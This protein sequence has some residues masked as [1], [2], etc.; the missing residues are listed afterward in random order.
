[1]ASLIR[2]LKH[3]LDRRRFERELAEEMETHRLLTEQ[4]LRDDGMSATEAAATSRRVMGNTTL[5]REDVRGVWVST[6]LESVLQDVRYA[7][8][9]LFGRPQFTLVAC[10]TLAAAIGLNSSLF[11]AYGAIAWQP[12]AVPEADR[13]YNIVTD[14]GGTFSAAAS[15]YLAS[16]STAFER[17]FTERRAGN[18]IIGDERYRASWVSGHYF[19]GLRVPMAAGRGLAADDDI[20]GAPP[21]AVLSYGLWRRRF[22]EDT[23]L[24]GR[25]ITLD[26][27]RLTVV[28][29]T[30]AGFAGT[31]FERVDMWLPLA[32][33]AI[34]RP[35][36]RWVRDEVSVASGPAPR[37]SGYLALAG[38]LA[39]GVTRAQGETEL[40]SLASQF[41]PSRP[42]GRPGLRLFGTAGGDNPGGVNT[43]AFLR[44]FGAVLAV[45][46]LACANVGS[47][48]LARAHARRRE[49][50]MRLSLGASRSRVVRQLLIES[51]VLALC[52][53][54]L[55][56][57]LTLHL[58]RLALEAAARQ[59]TALQLRPDLPV[60][61]FTL[62]ICA[63][64]C[65][66]FG[67]APALHATRGNVAEAL[68]G[69]VPLQRAHFPLRSVMLSIQ[70]GLSVIL[71]VAAGLLIRGVQ[72]AH[73][74]D[75]GFEVNGVTLMSFEA[76]VSA[77]DGGRTRAFAL[78]L[79][80]QLNTLSEQLPIG[81]THVAP[82]GSGNLKG[83]YRIAG[84]SED[85]FN[86]VYEVSPSYFSVLRLP[87]VAGRVFDAEER[88]AVL[89]NETLARDFGSPAAAVGRTISAAP[90]P[91]WNL[92][93]DH[94]IVGVV[95][96]AHPTPLESVQPTIYQPLSG[97]TIPQVLVRDSG[98]GV[99][100]ISAIAAG[101]EPRIRVRVGPLTENIVLRLQ[102]STAMARIATT[103]G[104]LALLLA[105]VGMFSVFSFWVQQRTKEIGLRMALGARQAQVMQLV[106]GSSGRAIIAGLVLG[107][108]GAVGASSVLRSSLYGLS[109]ID[110]VSYLGVVLLLVAASLTAT[111]LPARRASRINPLDALRC[112]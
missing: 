112:E 23:G 96:D 27:V 64:A 98:E 47:L 66:L 110:P 106:L 73:L 107:L 2:R 36:D 21:V 99:E 108:A 65:L 104:V 72:H 102:R 68:K 61:A 105:T 15:H 7:F 41:D 28:G 31:K 12:W 34:F 52:A 22:N 71:L 86:S 48:L 57:V 3:F 9:A 60:L 55:G 39:P 75:H 6:R 82:F 4:R 59:P 40:N 33:A 94:V 13:V 67:L 5:A 38:R 103:L 35:N 25:T 101:L 81:I 29:V 76:P 80:Q 24:I 90:S 58:P 1:M 84:S 26:D 89:V 100:R 20:N 44:M 17:L 8:R 14:T 49:I 43:G 63:L 97:R 46:L 32:A 79:V 111:A 10:G 70:V 56:L 54:A 85:L 50:A 30:A 74:L 37:L 16:R 83:N 19:S 45:L 77:Y 11:T 51:F 69:A 109:R 18:N 93:G 53:G 92:P 91:G 62:G 42:L 95:R 78:Q 88:G 87:V